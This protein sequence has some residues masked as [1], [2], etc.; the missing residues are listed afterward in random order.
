MASGL[1][2]VPF[3]FRAIGDPTDPTG[4]SSGDSEIVIK[5]TMV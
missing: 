5:Q 2:Q 1:L 3:S 4:S